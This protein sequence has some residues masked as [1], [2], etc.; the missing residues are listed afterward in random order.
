MKYIATQIHKILEFATDCEEVTAMADLPIY[1]IDKRLIEMLAR[2]DVKAAM[3]DMVDHNLARL[4]FPDMVMEF[5]CDFRHPVRLTETDVGIDAVT[6]TYSGEALKVA[7]GSARLISDGL[8]VDGVEWKADG[9]AIGFAAGMAP[10]MTNVRGIEKVHI[11]PLALNKSRIKSGKASIPAFTMIHIG[12]VYDRDGKAI[13]GQTALKMPVHMRSGHARNQ[14]WGPE[15]SE[16]KLIYIPPV[17]VNYKP[18]D[19]VKIPKRRVSR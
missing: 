1:V 16:R 17:L 10:L 7:T 13:S 8:K 5:E 18:G 6:T 19:E 2:S 12:S 11:E 9:L 3:V 14:A 15:R 4:P